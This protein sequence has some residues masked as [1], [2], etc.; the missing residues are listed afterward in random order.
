M[1]TPGGGSVGAGRAARER[2]S[3]GRAR[4]VPAGHGWR[5]RGAARWGGWPGQA[6]GALG[7]LDRLLDRR[8][9]GCGGLIGP[10]RR[11]ASVFRREHGLGRSRCGQAAKGGGHRRGGVAV[12]AQ[13]AH[14]KVIPTATRRPNTPG[15]ASNVIGVSP[16]MLSVLDQSPISEG[17]TGSQALHQTIELAR[18]VDRLGY[19][20]YWV[21]EHHGGPMLAGPSPEV[22]IGPIAAATTRIRVGSGGVMLPHYSP[23]KVAESFSL[24]A[25]PV[26]GADRPGAGP[27]I[28]HGSHDR[29][30][31][32]ARPHQPDAR[33]LPQ[34]AG[35]AAGLPGG[36]AAGQPPVRAAGQGAAGPAREARAVAAGLLAAERRLGRRAGPA[37]RLRR[38][39]QPQRGAHRRALPRQVHRLRAAGRAA[40]WP[41]APGRWRP[42][43]RRRR[44]SW[45]RHR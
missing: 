29:A 39:H 37:L 31:S 19:H 21:A 43:P 13:I 30:R 7:R 22:L 45:P 8:P 38:L 25:G 34:P 3:D 11:S 10:G 23:F 1:V 44:S 17:S 33:R 14:R 42:T 6:R 26:P 16:P 9:V 2:A 27:R 36:P 15:R 18:L 32:P 4:P 35:R 40:S 41:S 12:S 28:G 24:L 5:R 20:R